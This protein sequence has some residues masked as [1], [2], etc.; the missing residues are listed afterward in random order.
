MNKY[1]LT[2]AGLLLTLSLGVTGCS[3]KPSKAE[4][5]NTLWS[6]PD[7]GPTG[8]LRIVTLTDEGKIAM[9]GQSYEALDAFKEAIARHVEQYPQ[10]S[11]IVRI[12]QGQ[13]QSPEVQ[14]L[15][16]AIRE[17]GDHPIYQ[18]IVRPSGEV[19]APTKK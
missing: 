8:M 15:F 2:T 7:Q 18:A 9:L 19:S 4:S 11:T 1:L 14:A 6:Q 10:A 3:S 12:P 17:A 5:T 13:E 16:A